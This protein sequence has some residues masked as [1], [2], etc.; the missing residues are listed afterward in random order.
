MRSSARWPR[1]PVITSYSIHYTKLYEYDFVQGLGQIETPVFVAEGLYDHVVPYTLWKDALPKLPNAT[2]YLFEQSGH[3]PQ[4]EEP[5]AFA[6]K[7]IEWFEN[8][9]PGQ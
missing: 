8:T 2:F 9:G 6:E 4:S 5:E 7:L 3:P 1:R